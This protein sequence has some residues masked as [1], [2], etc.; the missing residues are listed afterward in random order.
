MLVEAAD[1]QS[2]F[3]HQVGDAN[4]F[5]PLLAQPLRRGLDNL[6]VRLLFFQLRT[7]HRTSPRHQSN[8]HDVGRKPLTLFGIMLLL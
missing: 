5:E 3:L 4:T 7:A 2:G 6:L 8:E 1:G